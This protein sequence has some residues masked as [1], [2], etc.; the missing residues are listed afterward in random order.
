MLTQTLI[1]I[2]IAVTTTFLSFVAT[3]LAMFAVKFA[4]N[5]DRNLV[6]ANLKLDI[7]F[8]AHQKEVEYAMQILHKP[9]EEAKEVDNVLDKLRILFGKYSQHT[10]ND[11][12]LVDFVRVLESVIAGSVYSE[13]DKM[14]AAKILT[15]IELKA[16]MMQLGV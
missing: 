9:H 14:A 6:K 4:W 10:I 1:S 8:D 15:H 3:S 2:I 12:E 5:T 16:R 13:G 11:A 7:L